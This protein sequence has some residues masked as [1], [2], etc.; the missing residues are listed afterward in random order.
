MLASEKWEEDNEKIN[1]LQNKNIKVLVIWE[2]DYYSNPNK[3]I[4]ECIEFLK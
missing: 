2:N 3:I 4:H 1:Q